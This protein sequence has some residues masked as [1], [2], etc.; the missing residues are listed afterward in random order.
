MHGQELIR[1]VAQCKAF[2]FHLFWRRPFSAAQGTLSTC[3]V[4]DRRI[5]L[6]EK[7]I[8]IP[9]TGRRCFDEHRKLRISWS[10]QV[11]ACRSA[12]T[13]VCSAANHAL[14][15]RRGQPGQI[16]ATLASVLHRAWLTAEHHAD[17]M[18]DRQALPD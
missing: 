9:A 2:R 8:G 12:A 5:D 3:F 11:G 16:V 4:L 6:F 14:I 1:L 15:R 13:A 17:E 7:V 10:L 18:A